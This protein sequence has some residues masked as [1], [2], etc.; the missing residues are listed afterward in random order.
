MFGRGCPKCK[1]Y[2]R[3]D[4]CP[5]DKFCPYCGYKGA[6]I[7]FLT[8]NQIKYIAA[9]CNSFIEAHDG[10]EDVILDLDK[11]AEELPENRP[12]WL[13]SEEQQQ[14]SFTCSGCKAKYDIL[15][16]YAL[17]PICGKGN[18]SEVFEQKLS[19]LEQQFQ[20]TDKNVS[21]RNEREVEWEKLTRCISDFE[22]VANQIRRFLLR[23]PATPKRKSALSS[24]SFQ[25]IL[26][27]SDRLKEW[28]GY[29]ILEGV[30]E[31]DRRFLNRMFN[32][33]HV[34]TH[35]AGR[36]DQEYLDNTGDTTVRLNQVLRVRSREIRRL[37]PL[38]RDCGQ[39]LIQG[40]ESIQ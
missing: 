32:R 15:G 23:Y 2:F 18:F 27:A 7:D 22:S 19:E 3:T 21:D 5:A 33:R 13:Y 25:K 4:S 16:E 28:Y 30:S 8:D 6:S 37:I 14:S 39:R 26:T 9:F 12:K 31:T 29:D 17:C 35:N 11:L 34:F 20:A 38:V 10:D 40:Y 24:L 1:S 36:V